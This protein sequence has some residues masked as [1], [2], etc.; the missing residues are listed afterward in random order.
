MH[1]SEEKSTHR[2]P[3]PLSKIKHGD[4]DDMEVED[5][6]EELMDP[7]DYLISDDDEHPKF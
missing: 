7:I 6:T 1:E 4:I 2:L 3:M 5:A